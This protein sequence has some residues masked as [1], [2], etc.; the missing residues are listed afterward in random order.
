MTISSTDLGRN[1]KIYRI[2][3]RLSREALAER[4]ETAPHTVTEWE[5]GTST[6]NPNT[7]YELSRLLG[8]TTDQLFAPDIISFRDVVSTVPIVSS[9]Y[10]GFTGL[11]AGE[12]LGSEKMQLP[13]DNSSYVMFKVEGDSMEPQICDGDIALVRVQSFLESGD[14][15]II[16]VDDDLGSIK[17]YIEQPRG[18][19]LKPF[20][21]AYPERFFSK[22]DLHRIRIYGKVIKTIRKW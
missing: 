7:I 13:D 5:S 8:V 9:V 11:S 10:A 2:N 6:P 15:G 17:K 18:V 12:I 20:N 22:K 19:I 1:I 21:E 4:L 3:A 16:V 14:L